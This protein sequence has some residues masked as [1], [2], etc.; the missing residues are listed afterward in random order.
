MKFRVEYKAKNSD[1]RSGKMVTPHGEVTTPVFMP[2]ATRATVKTLSTQ[3]LIDNGVEM[4]ISNAYHLYLR[5]GEE[6]IK[7]AGGLHDFMSWES[8][9]TTDSGGFQVFSLA[10]L[11]KIKEEGVEFQSHIDGSRHFFTPE[12]IPSQIH[13]D[14]F[15]NAFLPEILISTSLDYTEKRGLCPPA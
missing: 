9:I 1:A 5:P 2:V 4:L 14:H 3:D 10:E 12:R 8:P 11:R 15:V 7:K 13:F 6:I